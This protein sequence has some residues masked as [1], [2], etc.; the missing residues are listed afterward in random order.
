MGG[1]SG[2]ARCI[3]CT[4]SA[5]ATDRLPLAQFKIIQR[6]QRH[7]YQISCCI[8]FSPNQVVRARKTLIPA[9]IGCRRSIPKSSALAC[10]GT[11]ARKWLSGAWGHSDKHAPGHYP[12][13]QCAFK[14][15]MIHEVLQFALRIAFRCVLHRCGIQ[16]IHCRKL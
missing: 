14:V 16:D 7:I 5:S 4:C 15:L 8:S 13:A 2:S 1:P 10:R 3:P 9:E 6:T 11:G 12:E